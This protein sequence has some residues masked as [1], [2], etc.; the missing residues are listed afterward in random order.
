MNVC[1]PFAA[2]RPFSRLAFAAHTSTKVTQVADSRE[3]FFSFNRRRSRV[4]SPLNPIPRAFIEFIFNLF[5]TKAVLWFFEK[6]M[7]RREKI[8]SRKLQRV[9]G[10]LLLFARWRRFGR[11]NNWGRTGS[12]QNQIRSSKPTQ[13]SDYRIKSEIGKGPGKLENF[14]RLQSFI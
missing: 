6:E 8:R 3:W 14:C 10:W 12:K 9:G 1:L 4:E 7:R 13:S 2:S 5:K 11:I